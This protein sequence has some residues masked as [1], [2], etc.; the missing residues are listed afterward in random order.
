MPDDTSLPPEV[1]WYLA[2]LAGLP[3]HHWSGDWMGAEPGFGTG[4]DVIELGRLW[5]AGQ[6]C[7]TLLLLYPKDG[8]I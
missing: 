3:L 6:L 5:S 8:I 7:F 4:D 1:G 2:P